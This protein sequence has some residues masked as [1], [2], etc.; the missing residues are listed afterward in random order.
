MSLGYGCNNRF[1]NH[2]LNAKKTK[3]ELLSEL[4]DSFVSD[5]GRAHERTPLGLVTHAW[6]KWQDIL[7]I[8]HPRVWCDSVAQGKLKV[9]SNSCSF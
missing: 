7:I 4:G 2:S 6:I 8:P 9:S 3:R 1:L 5:E